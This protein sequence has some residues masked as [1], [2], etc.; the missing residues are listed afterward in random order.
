MKLLLEYGLVSN[1][2]PELRLKYYLNRRKEQP[3]FLQLEVGSVAGGWASGNGFQLWLA[4][5][6]V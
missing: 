6:T 4:P 3:L 2:R 1:S 5:K